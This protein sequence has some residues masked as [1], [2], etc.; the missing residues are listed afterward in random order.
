M[1]DVAH[2]ASEWPW[3]PVAAQTLAADL[4]GRVAVDASRRRT[5]PWTVHRGRPGVAGPAV[6]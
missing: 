3:V 5:D 2:F 6:G 1:V 4:S